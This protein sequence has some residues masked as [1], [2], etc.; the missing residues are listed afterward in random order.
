MESSKRVGVGEK[1]Q[2][3][4][5]I[6]GIPQNIVAG[7]SRP[8]IAAWKIKVTI[9][10]MYRIIKPAMALNL[11]GHRSIIQR[12]PRIVGNIP[13]AILAAAL[14]ALA[15]VFIRLRPE[16]DKYDEMKVEDVIAG[17]DL[18]VFPIDE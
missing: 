9:L 3:P 7:A 16:L 1:S 15:N 12:I 13:R 8:V 4:Y 5:H 2:C 14:P 10:L 18:D 6:C 11:S 17:V